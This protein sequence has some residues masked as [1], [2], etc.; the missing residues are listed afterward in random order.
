MAT[1]HDDSQS[2]AFGQ[3]LDQDGSHLVVRHHAARLIVARDE[4]LVL[5]VHLVAVPVVLLTPVAAV[6][7]EQVIAFARTGHK[8]PQRCGDVPPRGHSLRV[9]VSQLADVRHVEA[10]AVREQLHK[11][12]RIVDAAGQ[13]ARH[14]DV[15]DAH[16]HCASPPHHRG[17]C[18]RRLLGKHGTVQAGR[19]RRQLRDR[20][21][22]GMGWLHSCKAGRGVVRERRH[23]QR[24]S[25]GVRRIGLVTIADEAGVKFQELLRAQLWH[26]G[27]AVLFQERPHVKD[28]VVAGHRRCDAV[29]EGRG[30]GAGSS[31]GTQG[32]RLDICGGL[33]VLT[34]GY[35]DDVGL[36][37]G[38]GAPRGR[39]HDSN[40]V[41]VRGDDELVGQVKRGAAVAAIEHDPK[42]TT[43]RQALDKVSVQVIVDDLPS[44]L[45]VAWDQGVVEPRLLVPIGVLLSAT[46]PAVVKEQLV[47]DRRALRKPPE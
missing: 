39:F 3:A 1:I 7:E 44:A 19:R 13:F 33:V 8:P 32:T 40:A 24:S 34:A 23:R 45:E 42:L 12:V 10:K 41:A 35:H 21:D 16:R 27:E 30:H 22:D 2:H 4:R 29:L 15:V 14:A 18:A 11:R 28:Q 17:P 20:W 26:L 25:C 9:V 43:P 47:S 37:V 5:S 36:G 46:V 6:M 38:A 31:R